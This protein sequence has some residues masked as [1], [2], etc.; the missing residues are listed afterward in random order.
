[1]ATNSALHVRRHF[2]L[3]RKLRRLDLFSL[4]L[5]SYRGHEWRD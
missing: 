1:M 4:D 3:M 2:R 5:Y